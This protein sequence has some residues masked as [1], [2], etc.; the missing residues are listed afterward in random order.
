M[1]YVEDNL[2]P[3][4]KVIFSAKISPV[5]FMSPAI[6][7][8]FLLIIFYIS[9]QILSN[10][11]QISGIIGS[12]FCFLSIIFLIPTLILI[13]EAIITMRTSEFVVTN[14]RVI[15]K[16]GFIRRNITEILLTKVESVEVDQNIF[17]RICGFGTIKIT[18]TGGTHQRVRAIVDP[19]KIRKKVSQ[20]VEYVNSRPKTQPQNG[21]SN[22]NS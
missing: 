21:L 19:L 12:F 8:I 20:V 11:D 10:K 7:Y 5:V 15:A 2:M 3:N 6:A 1:S 13:L 22:I 4:E 16:T 18:G 9:I 14:K 17:G